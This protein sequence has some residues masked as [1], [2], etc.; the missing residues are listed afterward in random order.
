MSEAEFNQEYMAD[1]NVFEGQVWAFNHEE[2]VA[3]LS[4]IETGRLDVFAGMDVGYKDPT[5]FCVIG[6]DW[7]TQK[8]YLLDEYLDSERTTEQHAM[9]IRKLIQ[10]WDIDYIYIDSA[11]QQTRFDF[12]QN[13]DITTI[14]A[15]KSVLDG[16]GHVA[17]IVDND[18]LSRS[19][20]KEAIWL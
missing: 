15:K 2:C 10:K 17:G 20:C 6:Y 3:D 9:E 18:N 8:Y 19:K 13:Y 5:A 14:N 16:I 1:F 4:E 12:A 11:A 7:D